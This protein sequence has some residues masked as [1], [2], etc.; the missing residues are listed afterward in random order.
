MGLAHP[1]DYNAGPDVSITYH[2]SAQFVQDSAQYSVMSYFFATDTEWNSPNS[3]PDTLMMYDI[4][5]VQ[6]LYGVNHATRAGNDT[7]GFHSALGGAYNFATNADP[8]LCIWDGA[9]TDTINLSGFTAAQVIDLNDGH[10]SSVGG[11]TNN[12]SIAVGAEIENALGGK[13]KDILIGNELANDLRGGNGADVLT[14]GAGQDR[15]TGNKGADEF[16][17]NMGDGNDKIID[18]HANDFVSLS[19]DLWGG[20]VM[21]V[22]EVVAEFA[23]VRAGTVVFDFGADVLNLWHIRTTGGLDAQILLA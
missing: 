10:F 20:A 15:L 23:S 1:G 14:G 16:I 13:G 17:F 4:Y 18:L 12:L 8:L 5:A 7:Y 22:A 3:Y 2:N 21:T 19:S 9:G 11:Y 6:Q